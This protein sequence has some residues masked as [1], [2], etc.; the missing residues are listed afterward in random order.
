MITQ[1]DKVKVLQNLILQWQRTQFSAQCE[2]DVARIV[3]EP[4]AEAGAR[5]MIERCDRWLAELW[6]ILTQVSEDR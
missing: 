4:N 2:F 1:Q 5:A 3:N 6:I